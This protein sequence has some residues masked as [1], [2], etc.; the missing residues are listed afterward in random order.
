MFSFYIALYTAMQSQ[1]ALQTLPLVIGNLSNPHYEVHIP[2][3]SLPTHHTVIR[4]VTILCPPGD[5]PKEQPQYSASQY[6]Q[7][8]S[9]VPN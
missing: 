6:L 8:T 4:C 5:I 7:V 2:N 9:Q 3:C 1:S